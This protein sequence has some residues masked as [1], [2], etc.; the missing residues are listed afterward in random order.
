[1]RAIVKAQKSKSLEQH[2]HKRG[3][4]LL[5]TGDFEGAKEAFQESIKRDSEFPF[6][7]HGLGVCQ[8]NLGEDYEAEKNLRKCLDLNPHYAASYAFLANL[9]VRKNNQAVAEKLYRKALS[10]QGDLFEALFGL[11]K[12]LLAANKNQDEVKTLLKKAYFAEPED[13]EILSMLLDNSEPNSD[14]YKELAEFFRETSFE[15]KAKYFEHLR[16]LSNTQKIT[17]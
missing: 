9:E 14:L 6:S 3:M 15:E 11:A 7:Y 8:F 17:L 2:P 13:Y 16:E 5:N 12:L 10:L 1:M 4:D